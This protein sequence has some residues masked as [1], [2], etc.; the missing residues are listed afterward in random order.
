MLFLAHP[1][2]SHPGRPRSTNN[3][4]MLQEANTHCPSQISKAEWPIGT[5]I[6]DS[7]PP[8]LGDDTFLVVIPSTRGI[9][10]SIRRKTSPRVYSLPASCHLKL[11]F[12]KYV[13]TLGQGFLEAQAGIKIVGRTISLRY[14]DDTT[15]MAGSEEELKSLQMKGKGE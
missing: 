1:T 15:L 7:W 11:S 6:L 10:D 9:C 14:A 4:L 13:L 3:H 8:V 2:C 5:L 12:L